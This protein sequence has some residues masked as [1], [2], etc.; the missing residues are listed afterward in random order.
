MG[1]V[2]IWRDLLF[3]LSSPKAITH[4]SQI[5]R[6]LSTAGISIIISNLEFSF[7][8]PILHNFCNQSDLMAYA[9]SIKS[10]MGEIKIFCQYKTLFQKVYPF[11]LIFYQEYVSIREFI[12]NIENI[13]S[14]KK[15]QP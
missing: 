8:L 4:T 14:H 6:C 3:F 9:H 1:P 2:G 12:L 7:K 11:H 13:H 15:I 5:S 10:C